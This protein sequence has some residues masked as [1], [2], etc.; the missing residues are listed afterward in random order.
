MFSKLVRGRCVSFSLDPIPYRMSGS[1]ASGRS[2]TCI[3]SN[4]AK[5]EPCT[6]IALR[7]VHV[8]WRSTVF[9]AIRHG[10]RSDDYEARSEHSR[11]EAEGSPRSPDVQGRVGPRSP[12][13]RPC[14]EGRGDDPALLQAR[15]H[16]RSDGRSPEGREGACGAHPEGAGTVDEEHGSWLGHRVRDSRRV[17]QR[18]SAPA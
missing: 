4:T 3:R 2:S 5:R 16:A 7:N 17:K 15:R 1:L 13:A 6:H 8:V 10:H 14:G 11:R 9:L 18:S 12:F